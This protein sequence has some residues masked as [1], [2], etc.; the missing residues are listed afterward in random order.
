MT[1]SAIERKGVWRRNKKK[2][3][4]KEMKRNE[5]HF[6]FIVYVNRKV[7]EKQI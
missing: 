3:K 1:F 5:R 2:K 4:G 7:A 6:K